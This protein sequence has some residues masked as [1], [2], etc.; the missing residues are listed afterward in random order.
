MG[1]D[2]VVVFAVQVVLGSIFVVSGAGKL[3]HPVAFTV[4]IMEYRVLAPRQARRVACVLPA[5]ECILGFACI[6]GLALPVI[7]ALLALLLLA[8]T[9]AISINLARGR[10]FDCHCFGSG[11]AQIGAPLLLRNVL[12]LLTA[13]WL[14]VAGRSLTSLPAVSSHWQ[15]LVSQLGTTSAAAPLAGT[16]ALAL[17]VLFLLNSVKGELFH[18]GH[19]GN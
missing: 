16:V 13:V 9:W 12:L 6:A 10:S 14:A 19:T 8:F 15:V 11:G 18:I 2:P 17:A 7:A 5:T 4:A 1:A 3:R